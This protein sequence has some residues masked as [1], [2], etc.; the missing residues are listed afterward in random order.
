MN[1]NAR[2]ERKEWI[3]GRGYNGSYGHGEK[4]K[5]RMTLKRMDQVK[6][7]QEMLRIGRN[8]KKC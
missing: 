4:N 2:K 8:L 6:D 7:D 3:R 5:T 1:Q